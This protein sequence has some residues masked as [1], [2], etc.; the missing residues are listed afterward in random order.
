[1]EKAAK[2]GKIKITSI[3]D[4]TAE[5]VE[6]EIKLPRG[7][8][9]DET[10][11]ALYAFTDCE[12]AISP[13]LTVI[14][15]NAPVI[16]S[17]DDVLRY[18]TEKLL[19]DLEQDLRIELGRLRERLHAHLLE[20]IFIE[21]T[22]GE[23]IEE[24]KTY[25]LVGAT[26]ERSLLPFADRL[27]RPV[28]P[29]DIEHLLDI[30]IKRISRYDIDK[31]RQEIKEV[32]SKI[33]G[34]Q[35]HLKNMVKFTLFYLDRLIKKYGAEYPRR[36]EITTFSE[37]E[38]RKVAISNLTCG[39]DRHSGFPGY[40]VKAEA[41]NSFAC[42]EYDRIILILRDG[43][44]KIISGGDKIF[45]GTELIYWGKVVNDLIFNVIYRDGNKNFS[46]IKRFVMPKFILDKEYRLF[47]ENKKSRIQY[48]SIGEEARARAYFVPAKR[49]KINSVEVIFNEFLIKGVIARG[50][51]IGTRTLRRIV[52]LADKAVGVE[53]E[54]QGLL[55]GIEAAEAAED[56]NK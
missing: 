31:K 52:P 46:Y 41:E 35:N 18:N 17:V 39:Y 42:S 36:T 25:E 48:L 10:I 21:L 44:Y 9:A 33:L 11:D 55:P 26:V 38:V 13:N 3:N 32:E 2:T 12:V 19:A 14:R 20:Q 29:E 6:V 56:M 47:P 28:S 24:C 22:T 45:V 15:D 7:V 5:E 53:E 30:R 8:H 1:V 43:S 4:Y 37:V 23:E 51:R 34:V 54:T 50:K 16:L 27:L 40:Q 49:A